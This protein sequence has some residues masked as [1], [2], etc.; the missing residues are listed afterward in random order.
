M[1][2]CQCHNPC[3]RSLNHYMKIPQRYLEVLSDVPKAL[4]PMALHRKIKHD[5]KYRYCPSIWDVAVQF[6]MY[7]S[8]PGSIASTKY[9]IS[10]Y[11]RKLQTIYSTV[12]A[13]YNGCLT[14][15]SISMEHE[16]INI[17]QNFAHQFLNVENHKMV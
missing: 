11:S 12:V 14:S 4:A 5:Y 2:L 9:E 1:S 17:T 16:L 6:I 10:N 3:I 13:P 8:R 15:F 7:T